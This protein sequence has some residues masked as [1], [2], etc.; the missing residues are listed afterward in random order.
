M[1][2]K[3]RNKRSWLSALRDIFAPKKGWRRGFLYIG[4]RVQRLPDTPHRIALGF[5]CGA[6]ASFTPFFTL[7]LFVAAFF[8][9][10]LRANVI[11]AAFG[12]IVGNPIS[13]WLI[14]A[15]SMNI[16]NWLTGSIGGEE[17]LAELSFTYVWEHPGEFFVSIFWPYLLGGIGPGLLC[18]AAFYYGL[19]PL[20]AQFQ[21]TR[22]QTLTSR[23]RQLVTQRRAA[24]QKAAESASTEPPRLDWSKKKA[25]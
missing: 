7:H 25:S 3:R 23:A 1:I 17:K 21:K 18:A 14:A 6:F 9:Y 19:R 22:R 8:A 12:T 4:K 15:I 5:A 10:L 16:G 20:V 11:A 2:F 13:F 24:R